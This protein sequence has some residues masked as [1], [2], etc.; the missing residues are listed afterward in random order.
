MNQQLI[1]LAADKSAFSDHLKLEAKPNKLTLLQLNSFEDP[2]ISTK[3][4]ANI[5]IPDIKTLDIVNIPEQYRF[6]QHVCCVNDY[7]QKTLEKLNIPSSRLKYKWDP[8]DNKLELNYIYQYFYKYA[9]SFN[10]YDDKIII[11][12]LL[13]TFYEANKNIDD[14]VLILYISHNNKQEVLDDIQSLHK[15]INISQN[16]SK[17]LLYVQHHFDDYAKIALIN[18]CDAILILNSI[19]ID[20]LSYNHALHQ[21]KRIISKYCLYDKYSIDIVATTKKMIKYKNKRSFYDHIDIHSLYQKFLQKNEYMQTI[22]NHTIPNDTNIG[23]V[24]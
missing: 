21:S 24:L 22:Y 15:R 14:V 7:T 19:D 10:Y 11:Q 18:A 6:I 2:Y 12:D 4:D 20:N 13:Y 8:H 5:S 16:Q 23:S 9:A 17:I 3:F 1:F